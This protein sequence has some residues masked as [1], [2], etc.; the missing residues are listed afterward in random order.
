MEKAELSVAKARMSDRPLWNSD[1]S[2]MDFYHIE[3]TDGRFLPSSRG[4]ATVKS[5]ISNC[6][7][8]TSTAMA[9]CLISGC[10]ESMR[11]VYTKY[12][13][14]NLNFSTSKTLDMIDKWKGGGWNSWR[15]QCTSIY[16]RITDKWPKYSWAVMTTGCVNLTSRNHIW[17]SLFEFRP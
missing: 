5:S 16:S 10:W 1:T 11:I 15:L 3:A 14:Q 6:E 17:R 2:L 4:I 13:L 8:P 7:G 9:I 12:L